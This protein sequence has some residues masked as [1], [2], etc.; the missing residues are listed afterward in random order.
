MKKNGLS[1]DDAL[2]ESLRGCQKDGIATAFRYVRRELNEEKNA[3]LISLPTGAGKSGVISVVSQKAQQ[4]KVLILC[5]R[6]AIRDQLFSEVSGKFFRDRVDNLTMRFKPVFDDIENISS[7][8]IY[9]STFQKLQSIGP[10]KFTEIKNEIDLVII[11][12][13]HAEPSP[14][15]SGLVREIES[16]KIVIT[17]TP[18][19]NDLFQFDISSKDSFIYSF[20][21]ALED[22]VLKEPIFESIQSQDING[23]IRRFLNDYPDTKC[24]VKC[25]KFS[26]VEAYY[27]LLNQDFN[28]LAIHEQYSGDERENVRSTVPNKLCDSNYEVLIH[29]RKLDEG[30][31]IP[32]AKLMVLTYPVRSGRELVQTIGRVVRVFGDV[33]PKVIEIGH[34]SNE[35]MWRNY[36][37]FDSSLSNPKEVQKFL[38]SLD[39]GK[40]I[41]TYM[42]A[43][44]NA[45]YFGNSFLSKFN[46]NNFE[47]EHSLVIPRASVCFLRSKEDFSIELLSD[48]IYWRCNKAGELAKRFPTPSGMHIVVSIA[49]NRSKFLKDQLFF[50]PSF[51]VTLFKLLSDGVVAVFDSR[52]RRF[53]NDKELKLGSVIPQEKLI[54]VWSLGEKATTKEASSKAISTTRKRP[55]SMAFKG[56]DLDQISNQQTNSSYRLSTA[57]LDIY[58]ELNNKSGSY[59]IGVDSGRI[60]DQKES[61][62]SLN[63]LVDWLEAMDEVISGSSSIN[64]SIIDSFAK[65][66]PVNIE[67][68]IESV[69][70]D[71]SDFASPIDVTIGD[72]VYQLDND[73]I[74]KKYG[75][76]FLLFPD[77]VDSHVLIELSDEEPYLVLR[78]EH[79]L[80][81]VSAE[82]EQSNFIDL[83]T[84]NLHKVLLEGGVGY[85][86]GNFYQATLPVANG[87]D[88]SNSNMAN[89]VVGLPELS[90][91]GLNEKGIDNGVYQ[92]VNQE[93]S[94]DSVFYLLD[95]LK[96]NSLADPTRTQLGPFDSYIP[97]ADIVL[98]TDMGT[99]PADFILSSQN[100]LVYV[101]IKCGSTT[102]PRSSAGAL[103][104]VGS[105]A[106]KNIEMLISNHELLRP[107]NWGRLSAPWPNVGA[108][109]E[110]YE[111]IRMCDG[112]R[113]E[114][115]NQQAREAKLEHVWGIIAKRRQSNLV[116]KE[117]WVVAANSFSLRHFKGQL[118]MGENANSESLQ[119]YQLLS[120][121]ISTTNANDIDLKVFVSE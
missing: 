17:A 2:W 43:F 44:P 6:K 9:V 32:Q 21:K 48:I 85:S 111:R 30:V 86:Q 14:V 20:D 57:K 36:R 72:N 93:F 71:F 116:K 4:E 15:W 106:I 92:V 64:S 98:N 88:L 7:K 40:L 70:F 80:C 46:L 41:E 8:G 49:F 58:N 16:H 119:A 109:Q 107:G 62:F 1:I 79:Q 104:E 75:N 11:D 100:K 74:F 34:N 82:G 10:E 65:P 42:E 45:S 59:Y 113:F 114:A 23:C 102:A 52:G 101:H 120:S 56:R 55:E 66:V 3:C 121:W 63:E 117:I 25:D 81:Y 22:E 33:E 39:A 103:A 90:K 69:I 87:F 118:N 53:N 50:E 112:Q 89:V 5:H 31:D 37:R 73:F 67:L 12:E 19:R 83:M 105:Q 68:N 99:E 76:G 108:E 97:N 18:Y 61:S 60:S 13:G 77:I 35:K 27:Y 110:M 29:Q 95:K 115:D 26:D 78:S 28:I 94:S 24:I 47:P 84:D 54:K 38:H 96:A 91:Q 51:E